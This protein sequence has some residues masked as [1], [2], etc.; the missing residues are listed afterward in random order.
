MS[1]TPILISGASGRLGHTIVQTLIQR[2][3]QHQRPLILTTRTPEKLAAYQQPGVEVRHADFDHPASLASAFRGAKRMLLI[4]TNLL[5]STGKRVQ[6][7]RH[8]IEAARQ[9]GISHVIYT[10][11]IQPLHGLTMPPSVDHLAT[12]ALIK[13]STLGYTFLRNAFYYDMLLP[14]VKQ[15]LATGTVLSATGNA[16]TAYIAR[17]DC[18]EAAAQA[19]IA[20]ETECRTL[21]LTGETLTMQ[22]LIDRLTP[23]VSTPISYRS[24]TLDQKLEEFISLGMPLSMAQLLVD[25]EKALSQGALDIQTT[26][27]QQ[28]T[29]KKPILVTDFMA[30]QLEA[31]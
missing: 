8:A 23:I 21:T 7:H 17:Q 1:N 3:I 22:T 15:A 14:V 27:L 31:K 18:A 2:R 16:A 24:I 20:E 19:L 25:I 26:D 10:S 9:A 4:S 13:Q 12:E 28:L 30:R 6:Q 11:F 5:E 29:G